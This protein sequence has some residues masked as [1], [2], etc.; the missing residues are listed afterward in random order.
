MHLAAVV[1]KCG[2][3]MAKAEQVVKNTLW[4]DRTQ[5]QLHSFYPQEAHAEVERHEVNLGLAIREREVEADRPVAIES[6]READV[7]TDTEIEGHRDRD[8]GPKHTA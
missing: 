3:F 8:N 4:P 7:D 2:S 6:D 1:A 5:M